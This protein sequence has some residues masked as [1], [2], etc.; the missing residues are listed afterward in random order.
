[1]ELQMD[2][3]VARVSPR[4]VHKTGIAAGPQPRLCSLEQALAYRNDQILYKFQ[5]RWS[6]SF[7]EASELFEET[8]KWMWLQVAARLRPGSPPLAMTVALAMVDEML[9]T[10]ILFTRE[11]IQYCD[12]NYGVYL[13]HTPMTKKQKDAQLERFHEDPEAMLAAE[14]CFLSD[15]YSFTY[16]LLGEETVVKW[17]S[18]Y[19]AKYSG[20][21]MAALS[22]SNGRRFTQVEAVEESSTCP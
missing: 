18:Q 19:P 7:E 4:P 21:R 15:M 12:D 2:V 17:Y 9:H 11:Y 5:E 1:M 13:H 16:E 14:A 8:K 22:K 3:S 20:A 6:V 10:F